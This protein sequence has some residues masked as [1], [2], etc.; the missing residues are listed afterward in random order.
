M[1]QKTIQ[2]LKYVLPFALGV[3]LIWFIFNSLTPKETETVFRA[4]KKANYFWIFIFLILAFLSHVSRS[5]RWMNLLETVGKKPRFLNSFFCV[6]IA[7]FMNMI[8][9][10]AGEAARCAYL[11]KY[12]GVSFE[13]S[14]GTVVA[15]RIVDVLF[16]FI[17]IL[18]TLYLQLDLVKVYFLDWKQLISKR[19]EGI[20]SIYFIAIFLLLMFVLFVVY[21]MV[22]STG[23]FAKISSFFKGFSV[24]LKSVFATK[25]KWNFLFHSVFIWLM[26]LG[27]IWVS[28]FAFEETSSLPIEA[29]LT[30]FVL[31][32]L[33]IIIT[34]GG[35]GAY[36]LAVMQA[37]LLYGISKES[38]LAAGWVIWIAQTAMIVLLGG[39]SLFLMPIYNRK[40]SSVES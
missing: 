32:T 12:E 3:Y 10:R 29:C 7:Y 9:P 28:F 33:A 16:L 11:A 37:L 19:I 15:E 35:I 30:T 34:P 40:I 6:F 5:L 23:F 38:G 8:L 24:G 18:I 25:K 27:M 39:M 20:N 21:K 1:L 22:K 2:F 14:L 4:M 31:A 36:P 13:K 17:I 26:Y